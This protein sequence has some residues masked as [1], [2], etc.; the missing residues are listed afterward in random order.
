MTKTEGNTVLEQRAAAEGAASTRVKEQ[1]VAFYH[2]TGKGDGTAL[3]LEPRFNR[4]ESDRHNCFYLEMAP[5]KTLASREADQRNP[6]TFDW[7]KKLTIKLGFMDICE[8]LTVLEGRQEKVG[9]AR[10]GLYHESV[11]AVSVISF[12]RNNGREGYLLGVSRKD[13]ADGQLV[14]MHIVLGES[15]ATGLRCI[16]QAGLFFLSFHSQLFGAAADHGR[17]WCRPSLS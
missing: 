11:K 8:L 17:G 6:A 15:E 7:E 12:T 10:S 3:R 2:P 4:V 9:G 1:K 5:Q 14:R 13:K 16:L